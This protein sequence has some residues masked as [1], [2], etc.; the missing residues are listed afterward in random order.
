MPRI[1][2]VRIPTDVEDEAMPTDI[3]PSSFTYT[4]EFDVGADC[5]ARFALDS[6]RV[7]IIR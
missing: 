6:A 1:R 7:R 5:G 3:Q 2:L 4:G